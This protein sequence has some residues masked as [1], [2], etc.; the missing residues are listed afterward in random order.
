MDP[1]RQAA[2]NSADDVSDQ[3]IG[4]QRALEPHRELY[5]ILRKLASIDKNS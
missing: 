3:F 2:N 4:T 5:T 1:E